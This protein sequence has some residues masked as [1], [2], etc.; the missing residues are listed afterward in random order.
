M[1]MTKVKRLY[2]L[3]CGF[4][5]IPK[6]VSTRDRHPHVIL[7]VPIT[8]YL[9]DTDDGWVMFDAGIDEWHLRDPDQLHKHFLSTNWNPPPVVKEMHELG[10]QLARLGLGWGDIGTVVLSHLHGDHSGHIRHM[11]KA[12]FV[13]QKREWDY[14]MGDPTPPA[15]FREDYD[16]E[17]LNWDII[18]GDH[19]L[20]AGVSL[21]FTPGHTPGHQSMVVDLPHLGTAVLAADVGDL[22]ENF[23]DL[24]LPGGSTN[25][26]DAMASIHRI[27][28]LV[29][30]HDA[31]LFLTHDHNLLLGL[32][33]AP[34]YYD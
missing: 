30:A 15:F 6:T 33:L 17:G 32:K 13:V 21:K 29:T 16:I 26:E 1:T 18:D 3:L 20:M 2:V 4:E 34:D 9:L 10:P 22:M 28:D 24:V 25:D 5:I 23:T 19:D 11:P 12:R 8:V 27:N 31:T 14:A 7:S